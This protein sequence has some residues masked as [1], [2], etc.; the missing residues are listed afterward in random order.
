MRKL[1]FTQHIQPHLIAVLLFLLVT[2]FFFGPVFFENKAI[3]QQDITQSVG[4]AKALRDFRDKTGEE[5]LWA[6]NMFSGMPA[7]LVNV[8]WGYQA[9]TGLK[10]ALALG[11]PH[12]VRNIFLAFLCYYIM[13]LTFRVKPYLAIA[14]AIAFGLSSYM[15]VGLAAGHNA[16]I[17]AIAFMPLV[18]AGIH[19][20]FSGKRILGVGLTTAALALHL[21]E[22]HL[23]ITYYLALIVLG[24]G[25]VQLVF[26]L[27][28]K[29]VADLVKNVALLIP[30]AL[31]AVGSFFGPLWSISEYSK[32]SI[33]GKS[34]LSKPGTQP[35]DGLRKDYAF[36]YSNGIL[37]PM[38]LLI[39]NFYGGSSMQNVFADEGSAIRKALNAQGIQYN[40]QQMAHPAYWGPQSLS[41]PYYSGAIIFFLFIVGIIFSDRK[42]VW[43]LI[44]LSALGIMLT[45]GSNFSG[46]NYFMFDYFPG[47]NKFRSVTFA[48]VITLFAMPLL[49]MTGLQRL[50]DAGLT[51]ANKKKLLI[52][53]GAS[54]GLCLVLLLVAGMFSFLKDGES[55]LPA[56]FVNAL[57]D[58]RRSMFRADAFRS[59]AFISGAFIL[60]Y[61]EV[62][63]KLPAAFYGVL[64]FFVLMDVAAVDRRYFTKDNYQRKSKSAGIQ[65]SAGDQQVLADKSYFRVMNINGPMS[66]ALTSY[67]HNSIGGYHGA[68]LK[69]YQDLYDSCVTKEFTSFISEAQQGRFDFSKYPVLNMLNTKYILYGQNR[70]NVI[71][72]LEANGAAWF[73]QELITVNSAN[74]E[75]QKTC[76]I[77]SK[78]QAVIDI[79]KFTIS[80]LTPDSSAAIRLIENTPNRMIY[81]ST[82]TTN[83]LAVF[84]EIYYPIGWSATI[85]G[86]EATII[87]ANYVLRALEIPAGKHTIEF[88]F[89]PKS[90]TAGNTITTVSSWLVLL[91]LLGSIGWSWRKES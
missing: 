76:G 44:P 90:F 24:Y 27:R 67:Y 62:F 47:Y 69:R 32:Y 57:R 25:L 60:I 23:Q 3:N 54:G 73:V 64:I 82:S 2:V 84:S 68:K 59:F 78:T 16:R 28:E 34:E 9:I 72:N 26:A 43:W 81:E 11:L 22:N 41:A 53:L 20:T 89:A 6:P 39:P 15:I 58:E 13:L 88:K 35:I 49:G 12:P 83:G 29:K 14:G 17:G 50:M 79:S 46:F 87:R 19:L 86:N 80:G 1:Y 85:D 77:D 21:R 36:E 63:K 31:L 42:Y 30:A 74:E 70:E 33:R 71:T 66:D 61:F 7:Y 91:I 75:I 52:A 65:L 10:I 45:W 48:I 40:P 37:E 51:K 5:G 18:V 38:T 55:G 4:A 8:E 56:W